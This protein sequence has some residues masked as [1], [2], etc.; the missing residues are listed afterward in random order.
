MTR[1]NSKASGIYA[2]RSEVN[3]RTYIGSAIDIASRWRQHRSDLRKG[4][5]HS[6][7]LQRAWD[8]Y[9]EEAFE[10][11]VL[12]ECPVDFLLEREQYYMDQCDD[13]YNCYPVAGSPL[14]VTRSLETRQKMSAT[15]MGRKHS[16]ESRYKMSVSQTGHEVTPETRDK[17]SASLMG[18]THSPATREKIRLANIGNTK[19]LGKR[20]SQETRE[21]IR[22]AAIA[23]EALKRE[24]KNAPGA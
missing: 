23:R 8:K 3:G 18:H 19:R 2:I 5:H 10:F 14:G 15:R 21:K 17:I 24:A 6:I 20:A 1:I 9:G 22:R 16:D 4:K 12:E 7:H 11:V 13:S